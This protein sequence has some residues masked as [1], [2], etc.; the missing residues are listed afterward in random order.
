MFVSIW[1]PFS[2]Y[3]PDSSFDLHELAR[4]NTMSPSAAR[5]M[6]VIN[7]FRPQITIMILSS[8]LCYYYAYLLSWFSMADHVRNGWAQLHVLLTVCATQVRSCH[9]F[10]LFCTLG[11]LYFDKKLTLR[12]NYTT[13]LMRS[14][15]GKQTDSC[16]LDLLSNNVLPY[17][18]NSHSNK[19]SF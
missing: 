6:D 16:L 10:T 17:L 14:I 18:H 12:C 2:Q 1:R 4:I 8:I 19:K 7:I 11:H 9:I 13:F 15:F 5:Y 3:N